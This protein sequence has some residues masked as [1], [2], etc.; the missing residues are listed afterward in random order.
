[1]NCWWNSC[2]N[3]IHKRFSFNKFHW[4]MCLL[5]IPWPFAAVQFFFFNI[6]VRTCISTS[7]HLFESVVDLTNNRILSSSNMY[8]QIILNITSIYSQLLTSIFCFR[9]KGSPF[10][11]YFVPFSYYFFV[12]F[13][14]IFCILWWPFFFATFVVNRCNLF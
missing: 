3:I 8:F 2:E 11:I 1:M 9:K 13:R 12:F 7:F 14:V 5:S 10:N 6:L 4:F